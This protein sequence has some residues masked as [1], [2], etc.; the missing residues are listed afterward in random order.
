MTFSII[1]DHL[2]FQTGEHQKIKELIPEARIGGGWIGIPFNLRNAHLL[3]SLGLNPPSPIRYYYKPTGR[4]TPLVHQWETMEFHTLN[5]RGYDLSDMGAMKT[6]AALWAADYLM[7]IG[8]VRKVLILCTLSTLYNV[9]GDALFL[10]FPHRDYK[11]IYGNPSKR[12]D[13]LAANASFYILNHH[14]VDIV[15]E[16]LIPRG[17]IDLIIIDEAAVYR[18]SKSPNQK[19]MW[20]AAKAVVKP[21]HWV[22]GLTGRPTP[23]GPTD[24]Y[25]ISKLITPE[26]YSGSFSRFKDQTMYKQGMFKWIAR[27]GC[28]ELVKR[29]LSPSIRHKLEDCVDL[30]ETIVQYRE[31]ALSP[32]QKKHY[33]EL[34]DTCVTSIDG[35]QVTAVNAAVLI[36]K[37]IQ[38][39]CG[40]VYGGEGSVLELDFGP[41]LEIVKEVI[42]ECNEKVILFVPLTGTLHAL[43]EKLRRDYSCA[44]IEGATSAGKRGEIFRDF[45]N[46]DKYKLLIANPQAMAHGVTLTAASTVLWYCPIYSREYYDQ[47]NAR[48]ARPGQRNITHVVHI[49]ATPTEKKVYAML[50]EKGRMQDI[51]LR[52]IEEKA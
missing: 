5:K 23:Q 32:Q 41:R 34:I 18:S 42:E 8:V 47:A 26:N 48:V 12:K 25:G 40:V 3:K 6:H 36:G 30:P 43:F 44:I 10:D 9:W 21:E 33:N 20:R 13:I 52:L 19:K 4:Y 27:P 51:I 17:D 35:S 39:A 37:L 29:L 46:T 28:E 1:S 15:K 7:T 14:G 22:W 38:A 50:R 49:S 11:I 24:A 31:A 16:Y 45:Q 2:C